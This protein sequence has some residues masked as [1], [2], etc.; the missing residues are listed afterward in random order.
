MRF[1]FLPCLM[2]LVFSCFYYQ[3]DGLNSNGVVIYT[4]QIPELKNITLTDT[5]L[6]IGANITMT[7]LKDAILEY[8]KT[9]SG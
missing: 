5:G 2:L 9:V 7:Q 6:R 3:L 4:G 8:S 1:M